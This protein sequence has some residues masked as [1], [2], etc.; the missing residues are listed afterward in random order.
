MLDYLTLP[1][2][3]LLFIVAAILILAFG[4]MMTRIAA[5]LAERTGL[6]EAVMGALFLGACT[7]LPEIATSTTAAAAGH[8]DLAMS[9]AIGSVAGQTAFLAVADMAYRRANL[10]HA[11]AS[12]ENLLLAAFLLVMLAFVMLGLALPAAAFPGFHPVSLLML[13]A[14][15]YGMRMVSRV[16]RQP[17]WLPRRTRETRTRSGIPIDSTTLDELRAAADRYGLE[18]EFAALAQST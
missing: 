2:S 17:M 1:I 13:L 11:A 5:Q 8:A 15:G 6:G 18:A 12:A 7:S 9:N 16:H 10:E 3:L 4:V 14:Y